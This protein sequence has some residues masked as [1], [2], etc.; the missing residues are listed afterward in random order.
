MLSFKS[1]LIDLLENQSLKPSDEKEMFRLLDL[2]KKEVRRDKNH[3]NHEQR[4]NR[5]IDSL[6]SE[7][8]GE[9]TVRKYLEKHSQPTA[10]RIARKAVAQHKEL[11]NFPEIHARIKEDPAEMI[12]TEAD[13]PRKGTLPRGRAAAKLKTQSAEEKPKAEV[14]PV[15][16]PKTKPAAEVKPKKETAK[17]G[18][19]S[20]EKGDTDDF[21]YS[22]QVSH[23]KDHKGKKVGTVVSL[24]IPSEYGQDRIHHVAYAGNHE[25][26]N[27]KE[28]GSHDS[29]LDAMKALGKHLKG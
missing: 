2:D 13:K 27:L 10:S 1:F 5:A 22:T 7:K 23:V 8:H 11:H 29:H 6:S 21:A 4:V 20:V 16:P 19:F 12:R 25:R 9:D 3:P 28:L 15:S 18:S 14:K 26:G 24:R 17:P